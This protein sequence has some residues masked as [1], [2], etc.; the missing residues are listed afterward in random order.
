MVNRRKIRLSMGSRSTRRRSVKAYLRGRAKY[1]SE[2]ME[3]PRVILA[4]KIRE[5]K[6]VETVSVG[7]ATQKWVAWAATQKKK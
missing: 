2:R 5:A 6:P 4:R 1:G 3:R 7:E